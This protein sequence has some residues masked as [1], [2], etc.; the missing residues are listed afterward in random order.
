MAR[1]C[2]IFV[3]GTMLV[4][5]PDWDTR[6][7]IIVKKIYKDITS[8]LV[9]VSD[10]LTWQHQTPGVATLEGTLISGLITKARENIEKYCWIDITQAVYQAYFDLS[11]I[12]ALAATLKLILPRSPILDPLNVQKIEYLDPTGIWDTFSYGTALGIDGLYSNVTIRLEPRN[13][14]SVYFINPP[15]YDVSQTNAYKIRVTFN[16]GYDYVQTGT[17]TL[18]Y[19]NSTGLVTVTIPQASIPA[20]DQVTISGTGVSATLYNGTY[21]IT[22]LSLT[23]FTYQLP[24]GLNLPAASGTF[25]TVPNSVNIIPQGLITAIKEI[26]SAS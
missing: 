6:K 8:T 13:W 18:A 19:N 4:N 21:S 20:G 12:S 3:E 11:D 24:A 15:S 14:A 26:V 22:S 9:S 10:V 2:F 23:Q 17:V 16:A 5:I 25:T 1:L 7:P